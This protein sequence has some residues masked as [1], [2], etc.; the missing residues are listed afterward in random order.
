MNVEKKKPARVWPVLRAYSAVAFSYPKLFGFS[1]IATLAIVQLAQ[2]LKSEVGDW[3]GKT[4]L[5]DGSA[6][7]SVPVLLA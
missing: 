2:S 7:A 4:R 6:F 3:V 1:I 5:S